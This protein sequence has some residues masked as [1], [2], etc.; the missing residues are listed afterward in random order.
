MT[1]IRTLSPSVPLPHVF[2][3]PAKAVGS[4]AVDDRRQRTLDAIDCRATLQR[5]RG[6]PVLCY[7]SVSACS[8]VRPLPELQGHSLCWLGSQPCFPARE[9]SPPLSRQAGF[10]R[11][12]NGWPRLAWARRRYRRA[13][14]ASLQLPAGRRQPEPGV[15]RRGRPRKDPARARVV[16]NGAHFTPAEDG[17]L[18]DRAR[19]LGITVAELVAGGRPRSAPSPA[20]PARPD[21]VGPMGRA[22]PSR[23]EPQ[24]APARDQPRT[25]RRR[26]GGARR[27]ASPLLHDVRQ[28]LVGKAGAA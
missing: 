17:R 12:G 4:R 19:F 20:P 8:S 24:S 25:D 23:G 14:V 6:R 22:R 21:R 15:T 11:A 5:A 16:K 3:G 9:T 1:P 18:R 26:S 13:R 28:A 7:P 2:E 27:G 10:S